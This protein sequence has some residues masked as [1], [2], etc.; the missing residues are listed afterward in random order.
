MKTYSAKTQSGKVAGS[1]PQQSVSGKPVFHLQDNRSNS[2]VQTQVTMPAQTSVATTG[3]VV[4]RAIVSQLFIDSQLIPEDMHKMNEVKKYMDNSLAHIRSKIKTLFINVLPMPGSNPASTRLNDPKT[5][6]IVK[7]ADWFIRVSSIGDICGML[8]HEIGVHTLADNQMTKEE[9]TEE[10][11]FQAESFKVKVGLHTHEITP[12]DNNASVRQLDH[13]NVAR[14]KGNAGHPL[15]SVRP[16]RLKGRA[17]KKNRKPTDKNS[18][19][20]RALQYAATTMRLGDAIESDATITPKE[21]DKRLHDLLNSFLF[22]YARIIATDDRGWHVA[23]KTPLVSQVFNWYK[24]VILTRYGHAHPWLMRPSMQPTSSTWGLRAYL[25]G[26]LT[27]AVGYQLKP[28]GIAGKAIDATSAAVMG[29]GSLGMTA[30]GGLGSMVSAVT[31]DVV[32]KGAA[33]AGSIVGSGLRAA[34]YLYGEA[35]NLVLP[36]AVW[37]LQKGKEGLEMMDTG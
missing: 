23:D 12:W 16:N 29:L 34:D 18:V 30:L 32:K 7:I 37:L 14:D 31:P 25:L 33:T 28:G 8:S 35:E 24:Q 11:Q 17:R 13:V 19:N 26:K 4:Q 2:G 10:S 1:S 3:P 5:G 22:D 21:K 20:A 36:N 27:H 9:H 6:I 15:R